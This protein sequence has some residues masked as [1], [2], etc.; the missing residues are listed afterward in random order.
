M[1]KVVFGN[2]G[3]NIEDKILASRKS[4]GFQFTSTNMVF[5]FQTL[6]ECSNGIVLDFMHAGHLQPC[7]IV[8]VTGE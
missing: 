6:V 7:F 2:S 1:P 8:P 4:M 3:L 5:G